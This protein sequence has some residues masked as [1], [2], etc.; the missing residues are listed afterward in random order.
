MAG[1]GARG[2]RY[3]IGHLALLLAHRLQYF[4]VRSFC[5]YELS[6]QELNKIVAE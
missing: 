1:R 6:L 4:L 2:M 3:G 5:L